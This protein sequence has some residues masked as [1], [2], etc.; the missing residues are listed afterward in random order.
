MN[1]SFSRSC[2]KRLSILLLDLLHVNVILFHLLFVVLNSE[3]NSSLEKKTYLKCFDFRI[4]NGCHIFWGLQVFT[5]EDHKLQRPHSFFF[6]FLALLLVNL[7]ACKMHL[8]GLNLCSEFTKKY[9]YPKLMWKK[10][11]KCF[12]LSGWWRQ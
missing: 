2:D 3:V 8:R 7:Y 11:N 5:A 6:R 9:F 4:D 10:F 12:F 1:Q